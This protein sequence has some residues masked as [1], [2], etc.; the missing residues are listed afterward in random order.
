MP[1]KPCLDCGRITTG[2][3]CPV[4]RR[5]SPYQ[6]P[7]WRQLSR[8]VVQRDGSCLECGSTRYLAA[9]HVIARN[10]GGADHPSN[11][12]ALCASCH[13]RVEAADRA[14]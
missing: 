11:L 9:H 4:C 14:T 6:Q 5:H 2:T 8:F 7:A 1:L 10:E 3:R 13:A 12:I